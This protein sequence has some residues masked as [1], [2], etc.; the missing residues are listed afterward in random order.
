MLNTQQSNWSLKQDVT[1]KQLLAALS[2]TGSLEK[3]EVITRSVTLLDDPDHAL[4]LSG[5]ILIRSKDNQ[6]NL[7]SGEATQQVEQVSAKAR[8]WWELPD[9]ELQKK[10]KAVI[11]LRALLPQVEFTLATQ[12]LAIRNDDEKIVLRATIT[13]ISANQE[14]GRLFIRFE[15]LRGYNKALNGAL[16][17]C[18]KLLDQQL[19]DASLQVM[20]RL[21]GFMADVKQP[22][23]QFGIG[24]EETVEESV[25]QMSLHM[26][27]IARDNEQGVI[28]DIDTEFLH[29]Y[30]VSLRKTRSL[31]NLMKKAFPAELHANLKQQLADLAGKTNDLRDL[32][33]FLLSREYYGQMLPE[34]FET[35]FNKLFSLIGK[36]REKARKQVKTSFSSAAHDKLFNDVMETLGQPPVFETGFARQPVFKAACKKIMRRYE[37]IRMLGI[38]IDDSTPDEEVH[39]LRIECKKL[40]Y[41]MEFFAELFDKKRIKSLIKAL[42]GLQTILGDFNDYS[43]QKEFLADYGSRHSKQ[44]DLAAAIN[45]LIA[46]LHQKQLHERTR[47][48]QAFATFNEESVVREFNDLF[49]QQAEAK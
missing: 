43:V 20:I 47:V 17:A 15:P 31:I 26:L 39:E 30:R 18:S 38:A 33:V 5:Q 22:S 11:D 13:Q 48:Q 7:C 21:S 46:V 35:G 8:F 44:A 10:V 12:S 34:N 16:E 27:K 42:K 41:M 3:D 49:A 36:D 6:L 14:A 32:D 19:E 2:E 9:S 25:R 29:Q 4:W 24:A 23:K 1:A 37:K 28:D 40:R 45:G